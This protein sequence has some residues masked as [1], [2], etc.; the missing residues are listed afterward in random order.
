MI[1]AI[2][3][4]RHTPEELLTLDNGRYELINGDL[5]E[6][7]VGAIAS[8]IAV[9]VTSLMR[10]FAK[11]QRLGLIFGADCGYQIFAKD[12]DRVRYPDAS[13]V[14]LGRLPNDRPPAGHMRI[15][16]DWALEVISPNELATDVDQ[17]I[18]DYLQAGIRLIWIIYPNTRRVYVF[19][20][21]N[22]FSRLGPEDELKGEEVLPGFVCKVAD[23]FV[24]LGSETPDDVS[25]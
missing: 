12:R 22:Q 16:P 7:P 19:R 23:L 6:K 8:V 3:E 24:D 2:Q 9:T 17:K 1:S 25:V 18:E 13:F 14:R 5:V 15:A 11:G 21:N 4:R 10:P 20:S